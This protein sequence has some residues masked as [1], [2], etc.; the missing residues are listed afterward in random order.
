MIRTP[1]GIFPAVSPRIRAP[2][3]T[4]ASSYRLA[5]SP[6]PAKRDRCAAHF[7]AGC[8]TRRH[9]RQSDPSRLPPCG[10]PTECQRTVSTHEGRGA[11][12]WRRFLGRIRQPNHERSDDQGRQRGHANRRQEPRRERHPLLAR[13]HHCGGRRGERDGKVT[14]RVVDQGIGIPAKSLDRIFERFYRVDPAR[15]RETGGSGLGLAITKHCVQENG[16]RISVWS[17]TGRGR[18]S[19]SS[20]RPP[21]MRM[22]TRPGRTSRHKRRAL[23]GARHGAIPLPHNHTVGE[24][25]TPRV[26]QLRNYVLSGNSR[27]TENKWLR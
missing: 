17:R 4:G 6:K 7:R 18:R 25:R 16:G 10:Y 21:R 12:R 26:A 11:G 9:R 19:P 14:I 2:D 27:L 20:C 15:S 13:T 23:V 24:V 22:T 1:Y 5:E 8:G 3:R